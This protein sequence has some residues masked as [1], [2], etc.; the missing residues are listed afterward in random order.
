MILAFCAQ[1]VAELRV[2]NTR[3]VAGLYLHEGAIVDGSL[4][5]GDVVEAE[6]DQTRRMSIR[7]N[8]SATHLLHEALRRRLGDHVAQRGSLVAPDRL[9]FDFSHNKAMSR[10]DLFAIEQAV[11]SFIRQDTAVQTRV[12]GIDEAQNLG[13]RALFGE[14]YG[15]EVRVVA[16]G[17]DSGSGIGADGNTYS[18]ELCGGTHVARTGE[19]GLFKLASESASAAGIR[20]IEAL[21]GPAALQQTEVA[22][23]VLAIL[24]DML[25]AK[26]TELAERVGTLL[27]ERKALQNEISDL[28]KAVALGGSGGGEAART[29]AGIPFLAQSLTGVSGKDLRGLIDE[30]KTRLGTGAVLLIADTGGKAAIAAGVTDDLTGQ[31]SAVDL[32]RVAAEAM[33]GKGGGGRADL[34]QGGAVDPSK[35]DEAIKAVEAVLGG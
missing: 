11:N 23:D 19:I 13:A 8:H 35:S 15:D 20:R 32:V 1:T 33:G 2:D 26:P 21:T 18:L 22:D 6:V 12:L 24:G 9:R 31:V 7:A 27:E 30:H 16:M 10:D 25:R 34:A 29:I 14:K 3:K 28:R 5:V 4:N 17:I